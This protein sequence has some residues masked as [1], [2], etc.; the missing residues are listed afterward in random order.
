MIWNKTDD[1]RHILRRS[2]LETYVDILE[3]VRSG[4]DKPTHV[5]YKANVCWVALKEYLAELITQ[6][7]LEESNVDGHKRYT[8]T[9]K[10]ARTLEYYRKVKEELLAPLKIQEGTPPFTTSINKAYWPHL[11]E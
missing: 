6:R 5:M 4:A 7:L 9:E 10:G 8:L 2:K 3:A 1:E 11:P